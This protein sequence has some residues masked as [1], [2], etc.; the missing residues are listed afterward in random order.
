[1]WRLSTCVLLS[2]LVCGTA[3]AAS[4]PP[5]HAGAADRATT[6]DAG[7]SLAGLVQPVPKRR[8][9]RA[10][11]PTASVSVPLPRP[12][13]ARYRTRRAP[14][15]LLSAADRAI[16]RA[17]FPATG[18][19]G[20]RAA[21]AL[22]A[23]ARDRLPA[24][25]IDW[26]WL[27]ERG[28][29]AGFER[30]AKFIADNPDWPDIAML[31]RRAEQAL[32]DQL[33]DRRVIDWFGVRSPV[34]GTGMQ[35]LGEAWQRV[36]SSDKAVRLLRRAW[37]E[38]NFS[39]RDERTFYRRHRRVLRQ[40]EH[41]ARLDRLLW[42]GRRG[43][44]NRIL[45][46]VD[47]ATRRL[48]VARIKVMSFAAGVDAAIA[49]VPRAL[50]SDP[51]LAYERTRW[52]R[53]KNRHESAWEILL[54]RRSDHGRA[55]KWWFERRFQ[56]RK[57]LVNGHI[58]DA[59]QVAAGHG[60]TSGADFADAEFLSGWIA[61]RFLHDYDIAFGHFR[62]LYDNVRYPVSRARGAYWSARAAA[63][64]GK[65]DV[66]T[67][68][69]RLAAAHPTTYYGQLATLRMRGGNQLVLPPTPS[70]NGVER[71]RFAAN[72]LV[73][74][75]RLLAELGENRRVR[76]FAL[77]LVDLA[78]APAEYHLV[79][80][81][82]AELGLPN[83]AVAVAKWAARDG[84]LLIEHGYPEVAALRVAGRRAEPALLHAVARQES[85]LD[86]R[87]ISRAGARG[88]MQLMP[89]TAREIA[90]RMKIGYRRDRL[91]SD[92]YYNARLADDYL[93]RLIGSYDGSY[94][95]ALAAYN[96]GNQ[97][98]KRWIRDWGDPR[99]GEVDPVDW[100]ELI[101]FEETRNYVQRV[102]E[103]VQVYREKF[104]GSGPS[105]PL[106]ADDL[107]GRRQGGASAGCTA[108][109][110]FA[111]ETPPARC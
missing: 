83:I 66:A 58:S 7:I 67:R 88:L 64:R 37:V 106:L 91:L 38:G 32:T 101:P 76:P 50:K 89:R 39:R 85:E 19:R 60:L 18:K 92:P 102:L 10:N 13:P 33:A 90:R 79:A 104:D 98:V 30:I 94:V 97:R 53:M 107:T 20:Y 108:T 55:D 46:R 12:K 82:V 40:A 9:D 23:K 54:A 80:A 51:G 109:P 99:T 111:A 34:T 28:S 16:Y 3:E 27:R 15:R 105:R 21:R 56:L 2:G 49:R 100:V 86:P 78:E 6:G 36:G 63:A 71:T 69:Y 31:R 44:A 81:L 4:P 24:K 14:A 96:A 84:V 25:V 95:L 35:R 62:R 65:I 72:E 42:D 26:A 48:A 43:A 103:A 87:A 11:A 57:L 75:I 70:S 8:P 52:R 45:R 93:H 61:L 77:R 110:S 29:G 59:Y 22:A 1:M 73:R 74:V 5:I 47:P 41:A 17:A 68:Y